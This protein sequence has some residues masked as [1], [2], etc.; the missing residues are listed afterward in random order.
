[1]KNIELTREEINELLYCL[2]RVSDMAYLESEFRTNLKH[3]L[4]GSF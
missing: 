4:Y 1:M 2:E 3:K